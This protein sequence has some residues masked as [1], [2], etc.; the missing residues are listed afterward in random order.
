MELGMKA[1]ATVTIVLLP[2]LDGTGILYQQLAK[3]L[4]PGYCLQVI[5][6]PTTE[7]WGY[8]ELLEYITPLLPDSPYVL[9]AE[10]FSGPLGIMIAAQ[11][12]AQLKG[13]VL[14]CTFGRNP[15]PAIKGLKSAVDSLPW[16]KL[17]HQWTV[18]WLQGPYASVELSDLL[19]KALAM[20][21]EQVIKYRAKQVLQTDVLAE[22]STLSLPL[23][24]LQGG[25]DRL[26]WDFNAQSLLQANKAMQLVRLDAP[27]FLLQAIPEQAAAQLQAFIEHSIKAATTA[28]AVN[29]PA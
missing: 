19:G 14:C 21:P 7:L 27:H 24:Y 9:V 28:A 10:S 4:A 3:Q 26:I 23:L 5:A 1:K 8:A 29:G 12:P 6:Y 13:L 2:G 22:F 17:V 25:Q 20:V 11:Q 16:N 18:S 15:L